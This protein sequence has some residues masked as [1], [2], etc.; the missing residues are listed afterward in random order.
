MGEGVRNFIENVP[1][2]QVSLVWCC[3]GVAL[4]YVCVY[5]YIYIYICI[6]GSHLNVCALPCL[7]NL[8]VSA[9]GDIHAYILTLY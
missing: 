5:I 1:V 6:L 7:V 8:I 4:V 2:P 9:L 3:F